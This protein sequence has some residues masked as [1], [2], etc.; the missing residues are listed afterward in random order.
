MIP[1]ALP[2][3]K[4]PARPHQG[5]GPAPDANASETWIN[6]TQLPR[7]ISKPHVFRARGQ[8]VG[9]LVFRVLS[10]NE[11]SSCYVNAHH[12]ATEILGIDAKGSVAFEE[13][14]HEQKA[15]HIVALACRQPD[16]PDFGTFLNAADV[17]SNM[18]DDEIA[19]LLVAYSIFRRESGPILSELTEEESEAWYEL[20][21][22]GAS[23]FPL[24]RCNGEALT[25]LV[26]FLVSRL[27]A[28]SSTATSS[29]GSQPDASASPTPP[30][31]A[32]PAADV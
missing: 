25:D 5:G 9:T 28:V 22:R 21:A 12:H 23:R 32:S 11:Q 10:A 31:S 30:E 6:F 15:I 2:E 26:M 14:Y 20:L 17:R 29:P 19:V 18:T 24:A 1:G 4:T 8:D 13:I 7:P 27:K 3:R 16:S